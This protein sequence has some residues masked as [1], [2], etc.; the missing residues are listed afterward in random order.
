MKM[1][2]NNGN[3]WVAGLCPSFEILNFKKY[4]VS[5]TLSAA[6]LR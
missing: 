1:M 6:V 5:E 2:Y 3:Y 4:E